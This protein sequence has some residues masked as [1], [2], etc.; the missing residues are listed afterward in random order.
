MRR[1]HGLQTWKM[2]L[3][4]NWLYI[5]I[6]V[7]H[8]DLSQLQKL[9]CYSLV[10]EQSTSLIH[11]CTPPLACLLDSRKPILYS[12]QVWP[13]KVVSWSRTQVGFGL[14][15][16]SLCLN[17]HLTNPIPLSTAPDE[18]S[19]VIFKGGSHK[20]MNRGSIQNPH[21]PLH[22]AVSCVNNP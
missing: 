4:P 1:K 9:N 5:R 6:K 20:T 2:S 21:F 18:S 11:P 17:C 7:S 22:S 3:T 8:R 14:L 10:S 12:K 13:T 16:N 19:S 15:S